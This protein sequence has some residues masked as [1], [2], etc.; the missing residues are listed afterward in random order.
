[1]IRIKSEISK[2]TAI[3]RVQILDRIT[4]AG[5]Q[6]LQSLMIIMF[7]W[8]FMQLWRVTYAATGK[9]AIEGFSLSDTM[10]YLMAGEVMMLSKPR[11]YRAISEAV[12][13]GSIAYLLNKPYNFLLYQL[14]LSFGDFIVRMAFNLL[15]GGAIVWLLVGPPPALWGLPLLMIAYVTAWL[16]DFTFSALIGLLAFSTE[17]VAPFEWLYSK[18][19]LVAG[20]VLVPLDF[21]PDWIR[22]IFLSMPFASTIYGPAR[23]FVYPSFEGLIQ[24]LLNQSLWIVAAGA[25]LIILYRK[26]VSRL[27]I[28]GG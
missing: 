6:V 16:L 24:L 27:V 10:W 2:Y 28:N 14:S 19:L 17:E 20:G 22:T 4:Y 3:M 26:G 1:M 18:F 21:Y 5:D 11:V 13:D 12:K 9:M 23:L 25:I 15:A 8:I 7:M